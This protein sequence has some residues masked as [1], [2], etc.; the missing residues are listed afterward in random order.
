MRTEKNHDVNSKG[1]NK[2]LKNLNRKL[3]KI[4]NDRG[5]L[6]SYSRP[7]T[8]PF[9]NDNQKNYKVDLARLSDK[10]WMYDFAKEMFFHVKATGNK[11][12]R[13]CTLMKLLKSTSIMVSASG[14]SQT[15]FLPCDPN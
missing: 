12:T 6:V 1:S 14:V 10:K 5:I 11:P 2:A 7:K 8:R 4:K 13:D 3:L 15:N 9:E